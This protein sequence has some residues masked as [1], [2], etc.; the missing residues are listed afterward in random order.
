MNVPQLMW[1]VNRSVENPAGAPSRSSGTG[2]TQLI[3][4]LPFGATPLDPLTW[5]MVPLV[6]NLTALV[7]CY[8]PARRAS[9]LGAVIV[10]CPLAALRS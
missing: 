7:A 4:S 1:N 5:T 6:L 8:V 10:R 3:E 2:L 9:Y